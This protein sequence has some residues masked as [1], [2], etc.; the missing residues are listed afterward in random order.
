MVTQ[1]IDDIYELLL[2]GFL[3]RSHLLGEILNRTL[4][5]S[6]A[7]SLAKQQV[8]FVVPLG[9]AACIKQE[10]GYIHITFNL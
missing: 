1:F 4:L 10:L 8:L 7:E 9:F 6:H 5:T 2:D 3:S